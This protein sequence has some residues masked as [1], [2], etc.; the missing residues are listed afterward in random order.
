MNK[1]YSIMALTALCLGFTA[2]DEVEESL[3]QPQT[4]P[5]ETIFNAQNLTVTPNSESLNLDAIAQAG[6]MARV[7][8]F[9]VT[10]LPEACSMKMVMQLSKDAGFTDATSLDATVDEDGAIMIAPA[11]LNRAYYISVTHNPIPGKAFVRFAASAVNGTEVIRIGGPDVYFGTG[12]ISLVPLTPDILIEEG[13]YLAG[14]I[15]DGTITK[16]VPFTHSANN[17]YDD[18]TF[19]IVFNISAEE[20]ENGFEWYI[21]PEST[22]KAGAI[23]GETGV[24]GPE[25]ADD[26][27]PSGTLV[28]GTA[29]AYHMGVIYEQ[30]PHMM[31]IDMHALTYEISLAIDQ[32][33]TPGNSNGWS[34]P[35]SQILTTTD[36]INYTGFAHLNGEF[37]FTSQPNWDGVNYGTT[38]EP[39]EL[40]TDGGA[41]NLTVDADA[42][43]WCVVDLPA[44][45]YTLTQIESVGCI[46]GFN[47]W[48][49]QEALKPSADFLTWTGSVDMNQGD[50]WKF[51]F[52]DN[53]DINLGGTPDEL[54]VNGGN[55]TC[56]ATGTYVVTLDLNSVPYT[57]TVVKQ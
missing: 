52:N 56:P 5:Q 30:G 19:A 2:C 4:N 21:V 16:A 6:E 43:Y 44:L 22:V 11:D 37:K 28:A 55:L 10:D 13:Y 49:K 34:Q 50:E 46:G 48:G 7:G 57:C 53:W 20:A 26:S 41:K 40:T 31:K 27:E 36:H 42:L 32:L 17:V 54:V 38:G 18:P 25:M 8:S 47:G 23:T 14:T 29:D 51:R 24:Y 9:T 3:S 45:H 35:A 15:S 1:I 39:N 12:E 33:Y